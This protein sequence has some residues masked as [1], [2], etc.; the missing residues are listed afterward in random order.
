MLKKRMHLTVEKFLF[1]NQDK[2]NRGIFILKHFA[3][4]LIHSFAQLICLCY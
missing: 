3:K 2:R 1:D 4:Y